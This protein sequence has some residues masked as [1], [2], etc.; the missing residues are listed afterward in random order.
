MSTKLSKEMLKYLEGKRMS[1]FEA[2]QL[3]DELVRKSL[4]SRFEAEM[5]RRDVSN[6]HH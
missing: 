3:K 2:A 5:I 4:K 1:R 6:D